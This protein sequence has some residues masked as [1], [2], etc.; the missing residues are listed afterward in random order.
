MLNFVTNAQ[1]AEPLRDFWAG[2]E[3]FGACSH[4]SIEIAPGLL[5]CVE[6]ISQNPFYSSAE[7]EKGVFNCNRDSQAR[8]GLP[9]E[10][11]RD[12]LE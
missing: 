4:A 6:G 9:M 7:Y 11:R 1:F 2:V 8:K 10:A 3:V 12:K 5:G